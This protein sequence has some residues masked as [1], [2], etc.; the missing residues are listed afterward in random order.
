[1]SK[2]LPKVSRENETIQI[3]LEINKMETGFH[4]GKQR[5]SQDNL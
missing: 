1:M 2:K 3:K 5:A 4:H